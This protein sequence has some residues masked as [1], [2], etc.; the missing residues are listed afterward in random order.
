MM[1]LALPHGEKKPLIMDR[2]FRKLAAIVLLVSLMTSEAVWASFLGLIDADNSHFVEPIAAPLYAE[3][4]IQQLI[5]M[6]ADPE[7]LADLTPDEALE[8]NEA[9]PIAALPVEAARPFHTLRLSDG[10]GLTALRCLTQ[11]VYYEAAYEP[12]QGR[13]AVAQVVLN[14][15][16][17]TAFPKSVCG[18]VYQGV[19]RPVCQFSFTCDG[20]L[21]RR[22]NPALWQEAEAIAQA[23][24]NGYVETSVGYATH[25]HANYVSPYWAPKLVKINKIGAHIFYRWPGKWGMSS[26]F[27]GLHSGVEAIPTVLP[28]AFISKRNPGGFKLTATEGEIEAAEAAA[29]KPA[30]EPSPDLRA[31]RDF[32][33]RLDVSKGWIPSI[34]EP[35]DTYHSSREIARQQAGEYEIPA[36]GGGQ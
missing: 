22:P 36:K 4:D 19:N 32:G 23:A 14:R 30:I 29:G 11:A 34:P 25:Y 6:T 24:L 27:S 13:R 16:R 12:L 5:E 31:D 20:S 3:Q 17:H 1:Q 7:Q 15:M 2:T 35:E 9:I 28:R 8:R 10:T 26:A 33:G 21:N 18:V